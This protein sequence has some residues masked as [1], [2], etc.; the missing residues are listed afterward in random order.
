MILGI[1]MDSKLWSRDSLYVSWV[2]SPEQW[3]QVISIAIMKDD[4]ILGVGIDHKLYSRAHFDTP[5]VKA[6]DTCRPMAEMVKSI[7]ATEDGAVIGVGIDNK[8][9]TRE[10][11]DALWVKATDKGGEV[12]S[13]TIMKD[14]TIVNICSII[15]TN[16]PVI[17]S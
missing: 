9:Y 14:G 11:L 2:K 7:A 5:W 13:V 6:R 8:L 17:N 1:G 15:H 4:T 3:G 12:K 16:I 10:N